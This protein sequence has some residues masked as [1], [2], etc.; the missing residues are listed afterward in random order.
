MGSKNS[1]DKNNKQCISEGLSPIYNRYSQY[2][3][4]SF[5]IKRCI[6]NIC[7]LSDCKWNI[8][9]IKNELNIDM[10]FWEP[11]E[12]RASSIE[13]GR[14]QINKLFRNNIA[15]LEDDECIDY[16]SQESGL[17][18]SSSNSQF[19]TIS[20][21]LCSEKG[22]DLI[23]NLGDT[24]PSRVIVVAAQQKELECKVVYGH[25]IINWRTFKQSIGL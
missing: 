5:L 15:L 3:K 7:I 25:G 14:M 1:K 21:V 10:K 17:I 8:D 18:I 9:A 23:S 19:F 24:E 12:F 20:I 4:D 13:E 11:Y 22:V 6:K 2:T 16:L